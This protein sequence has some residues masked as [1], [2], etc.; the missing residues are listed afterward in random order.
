MKERHIGR[1]EKLPDWFT[2]KD[3][4]QEAAEPNPELNKEKEQLLKKLA[5]KKVLLSKKDMPTS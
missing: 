3:K 2:S 1:Q 4:P 5:E